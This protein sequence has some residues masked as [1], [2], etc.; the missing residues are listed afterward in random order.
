M[1]KRRKLIIVL[2]S[3]ILFFLIIGGCKSKRSVVKEMSPLINEYKKQPLWDYFN[4]KGSSLIVLNKAMY[5]LDNGDSISKGVVL[6]YYP[7]EKKAYGE[8]FENLYPKDKKVEDKLK[9]LPVILDGKAYRMENG[10][11]VEDPNYQEEKLNED[12]KIIPIMFDSEGY[13]VQEGVELTEEIKNFK[14]MLEEFEFSKEYLN[15]LKIKKS[16]YNF[17]VPN[18]SLSYEITKKNEDIKNY[19]KKKSL[20]KFGDGKEIEFTR[21]GNGYDGGRMKL[22]IKKNPNI[23]INESIRRNR[24]ENSGNNY[25]ALFLKEE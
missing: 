25:R 1:K 2:T 12:E 17:E 18:Y 4:T 16:G 10:K 14:F 3:V 11:Y 23:Y 21:D 20:S 6:K 8:Y 15:Q 9:D 19:V 7:S 22:D 5:R 13:H 24:D